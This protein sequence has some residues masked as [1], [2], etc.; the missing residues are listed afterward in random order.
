VSPVSIRTATADDALAVLGLWGAAGSVPT[1]TDDVQSIA[2]LLARDPRAL[3]LAE[4]NG[5]L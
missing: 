5:E 1:R 3:L 4:Q 2:A